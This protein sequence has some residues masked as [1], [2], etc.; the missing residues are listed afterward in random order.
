MTDATRPR[1]REMA[2]TRK[3]DSSTVLWWTARETSARV[4]EGVYLMVRPSFPH[5]AGASA[6]VGSSEVM[7]SELH[8]H[9][10]R[11]DAELLRD[12]RDIAPTATQ[13]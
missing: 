6:K 13:R 10:T 5:S 8:P 11:G 9:R 4:R 2:P 1:R 3:D 12:L 7:G